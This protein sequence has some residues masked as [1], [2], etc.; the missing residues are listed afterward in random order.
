M[1][2][3]PAFSPAFDDAKNGLLLVDDCLAADD[4]P[5]SHW[6]NKESNSVKDEMS[7]DGIATTVKNTS[8]EDTPSTGF[9]ASEDRSEVATRTKKMTIFERA[10][11][12]ASGGPSA[13]S[14]Q[15][16]EELRRRKVSVQSDSSVFLPQ[17]V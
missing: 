14:S 17:L 9:G 10:K 2:C 13:T 4:A 3:H 15:N 5:H 8:V 12:R 16:A 7:F 1:K 6:A 11:L